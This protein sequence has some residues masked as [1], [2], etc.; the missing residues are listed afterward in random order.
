MRVVVHDRY[1]PPDVLRVEDVEPPVPE[2]DEVLVRVRATTVN[3]T[4]CHMRRA[5]PVLWRFML[6]LRG[7]K[8]KILGLE[9]AGE[10][11]VVGSAVTDFQI[12]DRVFGMRSGAHAEYLCVKGTRLVAQ[13]PAGMTFEDAAAVC[14][15]ACYR[16]VVDRVYPLEQAVDAHTYVES[17]QKVGN[18][19]LTLN[20]GAR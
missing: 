9:F 7:P 17:W 2:D 14:D 1:G 19:V 6:G 20:G 12:G 16:P 8:R 15:G 18:V 5:R 11:E 10:V 4:D 13:I 3:Q